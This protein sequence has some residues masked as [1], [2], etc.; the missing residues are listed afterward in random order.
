MA[1]GA[2][3]YCYLVDAPLL[4]KACAVKDPFTFITCAAVF[5]STLLRMQLRLNNTSIRSRSL[6][7]AVM[8]TWSRLA[9]P[10]H[11]ESAAVCCILLQRQ[12]LISL[13]LRA[14]QQLNRPT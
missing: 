14:S 13:C 5:H 2:I 4:L 12:L 1:Y 6:R 8:L 11:A 3:V 10:I 7:N 9:Y